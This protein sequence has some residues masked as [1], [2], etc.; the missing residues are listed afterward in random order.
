[1]H[2]F[3]FQ[4]FVAMHQTGICYKPVMAV[5]AAPFRTSIKMAL[6]LHL[7]TPGQ[8]L[9]SGTATAAITVQASWVWP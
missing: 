6:R 5:Q 3:S 4:L 2:L 8:T 1:M 7:S 9:S